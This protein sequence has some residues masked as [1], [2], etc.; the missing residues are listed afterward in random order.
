MTSLL[1]FISGHNTSD[2]DIADIINND[3]SWVEQYFLAE[4]RSWNER[5]KILCY[6]SRFIVYVRFMYHHHQK[7]YILYILLFTCIEVIGHDC[8]VLSCIKY[9]LY[10]S[11]II[12]VTSEFSWKIHWNANTVFEQYCDFK[13]NMLYTDKNDHKLYKSNIFFM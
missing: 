8:M 10:L 13:K 9:H 6:C 3:F 7:E 5:N 12:Y 11:F 2:R 1:G 4:T